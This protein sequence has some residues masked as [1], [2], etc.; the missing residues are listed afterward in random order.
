MAPTQPRVRRAAHVHT[1]SHIEIAPKLV[2]HHQIVRIDLLLFHR[3][4]GARPGI[5]FAGRQRLLLRVIP[6]RWMARPNERA[7]R[8]A[9]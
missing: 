2:N 9:P 1:G 5:P 6:S 4:A 8:V 7:L 3:E